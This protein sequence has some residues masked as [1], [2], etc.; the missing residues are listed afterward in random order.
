MQLGLVGYFVTS[1]LPMNLYSSLID[2]RNISTR[3][4]SGRSYGMVVWGPWTRSKEASMSLSRLIRLWP[5][6]VCRLSLQPGTDGEDR[7]IPFP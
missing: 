2:I 4:H 5:G 3:S 1:G 7:G 6:N